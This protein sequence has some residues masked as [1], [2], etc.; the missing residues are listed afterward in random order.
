MSVIKKSDIRTYSLLGTCGVFG[1]AMCDLADEDENLAVVTS[2]LCYYSGL[3][4]FSGKHPNLLYNVGI[5]EQNM[6]GIAAGM[7]KE[8]LNVFATTYASFATTRALDQ[9]KVSMG[10][11]KLPVKLVGLTAGYSVGILGTTHVALEDI[12]IMRSIPNIIL[13]SPADGL[14]TYKMVMKAAKIKEP[15]YLRLSGTMNNPIVYT[16]DYELEI[17]K[18]VELKTDGDIAV[19]A[20]GTMVFQCKKA[21][22][23][24]EGSGIHCSLYDFHTIKPLDYDCLEEILKRSKAVITVEEHFIYGGLG[25]AV[26]EVIAGKK[27]QIP[28][29]ILGVKD[30]YLHAASYSHLLKCNQLD[31]D[32]I[33]ASIKKFVDEIG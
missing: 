5:A 3:E 10:Y 2:D 23:I 27:N 29:L 9:V 25:G 18:A 33:A 22:E 24:L 28:Q 14:E 31:A 21:I 30:R 1:K 7:A 6:V 19:I 20:T 17:G 26:A 32:G 12:S 11:M 8:G 16:E 4:R 15:V 13:L